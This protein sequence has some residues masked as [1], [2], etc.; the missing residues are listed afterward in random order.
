MNR[1]DTRSYGVTM[2]ERVV[3]V[4]TS[5]RQFDFYGPGAM[6]P[7]QNFWFVKSN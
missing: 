3:G 2:G 6:A 7:D 1:P 5:E 4:K